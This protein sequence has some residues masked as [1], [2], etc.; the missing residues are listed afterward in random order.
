M[1]SYHEP[2]FDALA[3]AFRVDERVRTLLEGVSGKMA[4]MTP[5]ALAGDS[6]RLF[7]SLEQIYRF[8]VLHDLESP[9]VGEITRILMHSPLYLSQTLDLLRLWQKELTGMVELC[10]RTFHRPLTDLLEQYPHEELPESLRRLDSGGKVPADKIIDIKLRDIITIIPGLQ[11]LDGILNLLTGG[12]SSLLKEGGDR[13]LGSASGKY[14]E[15]GRK[16]WFALHDLT[17]E[18]ASLLAPLLGS[19]AKNLVSLKE[20]GLSV[21]YGVIFPSSLT[22]RDEGFSGAPNFFGT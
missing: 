21:P 14:G 17:A 8:L 16:P 4:S 22:G 10:Y 5:Q 9:Q 19:K 18:E 15:Y 13:E 2:K 6:V 11:E 1:G 12:L 3:E 20:K 7:R